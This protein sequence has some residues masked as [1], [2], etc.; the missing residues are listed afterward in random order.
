MVFQQSRCWGI[1]LSINNLMRF[2]FGTGQVAV[3][4]SIMRTLVR[5]AD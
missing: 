3:T 1:P 2:A 4:F 5:F